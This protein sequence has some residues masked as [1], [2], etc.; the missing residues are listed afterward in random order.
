MHRRSPPPITRE[1][2]C[3]P[4]CAGSSQSETAGLSVA[5]GDFDGSLRAALPLGGKALPQKHASRRPPF[6]EA[7]RRISAR[8]A[9]AGV[10]GQ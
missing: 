10:R 1:D 5:A 4:A 2:L 9:A 8:G 6:H 7:F 3:L